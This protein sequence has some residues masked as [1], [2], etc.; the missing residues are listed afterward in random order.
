MTWRKAARLRRLA[1]AWL[2]DHCLG[3]AGVRIDVIR[4]PA[5][6]LGAPPRCSTSGASAHEPGANTV[7]GPHRVGGC[8]GQRGGR[9]HGGLP[10]FAVQRAARRRRLRPVDGSGQGRHRQQ[11]R[12]AAAAVTVNPRP[13]RS[14][15]PGPGSTCR[16]RW[17]CW[18]PP[19]PSRRRSQRASCTS[20]SSA[21]TGAIRPVRG[22][23]PACS[24][25]AAGGAGDV[26]VPVGNAAGQCS[27]PASAC[28]RCPTSPP[29][30]R[31]TAE[32]GRAGCPRLLRR[33]G[34]AAAGHG[35]LRTTSP[36]R[37][38]QARLA[39][40]LA[41][42]GGHHLFLMGPQGRGRRAGR[43]PRLSPP[44]LTRAQSLDVLAV[45]RSWETS[46]RPWTSR[47]QPPFVAPHHSASMTAIVGGG[48][49]VIRP[50]AISQAHH[51]VLFLDEAAEFR[52]AVLQACVSRWSRERWWW[53]R[54]PVGAV[55]RPL[56]A[57]H[58]GQPVPV[59]A[60]VREKGGV[61]VPAAR[62]A[63]VCREADR[64]A[65]GPSSTCRS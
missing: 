37:G 16:S 29:W 15:S 35:R 63:C 47:G 8:H 53:P 34:T 24:P 9:H 18:W 51:G 59:R 39:L 36:M 19:G 45:P 54:P 50:G 41:A 11:R 33:R 58:G 31:T 14:R 30:W 38:S 57:R 48:S 28:T 17:P 61:L 49:G 62:A 56:P 42:A 6:G 65:A 26:V 7:R 60:R 46:L 1:S 44:P 52:V 27:S 43:T 5:H 4:H 40:E 32:S 64:P 2:A 12:A 20:G 3:C 10:H 21:W 25:A 13:P 22:F 55:P 23:C